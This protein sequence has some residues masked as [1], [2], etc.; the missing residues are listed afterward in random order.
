M[1]DSKSPD[2][3]YIFSEVSYP[4]GMVLIIVMIIR[5]DSLSEYHILQSVS[6]HTQITNDMILYMPRHADDLL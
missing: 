3:Q 2:H 6:M 1:T 5:I 4:W